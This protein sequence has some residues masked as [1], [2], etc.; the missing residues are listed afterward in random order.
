MSLFQM[1]FISARGSQSK[2]LLR[3]RTAVLCA[4]SIIPTVLVLFK[5]QWRPHKRTKPRRF[6]G[7]WPHRHQFL[8][9]DLKNTIH[10]CVLSN[11][12][13]DN[14]IGIILWKCISMWFVWARWR[15]AIFFPHRVGGM[16]GIHSGQS[17]PEA[18]MISNHHSPIYTHTY[19]QHI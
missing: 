4:S 11:R 2:C 16:Q 19:T 9:P 14:R 17:S 15:K 8:S 13:F 12:I 5:A 10:P 18:Y 1:S 3:A 6:T 7:C